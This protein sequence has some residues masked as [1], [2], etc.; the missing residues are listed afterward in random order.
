MQKIYLILFLSVYLQDGFSQSIEPFI[1]LEGTW[2]MPRPKG[3]FRLETWKQKDDVTLSGKGL[4][5]INTDTSLLES[6]EIK[7]DQGES[8]YIPTVPDQNNATAIPFKLISSTVHQFVFENPQHDFPQRITY[9]FKPV[10]EGSTLISSR[11]DTLDVDVTSLEGDGI[12]YQF[13]RKK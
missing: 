7:I 11:G 3:G 5:V 1:W 4:K 10:M 13:T 12:H 6:I 8:W 9:V 2:E